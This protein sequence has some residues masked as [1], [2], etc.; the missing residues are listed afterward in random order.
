MS[1]PGLFKEKTSN[2][3]KKLTVLAY[4][5]SG[6]LRLITEL[7]ENCL[8]HQ[9]FRFCS[10]SPM[11]WETRNSVMCTNTLCTIILWATQSTTVEQYAHVE[12]GSPPWDPTICQKW[13]KRVPNS[14]LWSHGKKRKKW[15]KSLNEENKILRVQF[16]QI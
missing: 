16:A 10:E 4:Y 14:A 13:P 7:S 2:F 6:I 1:C 15:P 8:Q 12:S 5:M 9:L 11:L 3:Q